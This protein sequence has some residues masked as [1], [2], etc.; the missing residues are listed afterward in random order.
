MLFAVGC[1]LVVASLPSLSAAEPPHPGTTDSDLNASE[2]AT[3]WSNVPPGRWDPQPGEG[4][5]IHEIASGTDLTFTEPPDTAQR[6]NEYGHEQFEP[7][8]RDT[9]VHPDSISTHSHSF[10]KDAHATVFSVNPST[11]A[12]VG[13]DETRLYLA[14]N[15]TVRG[16]VD[17]RID[18]PD[19]D[20]RTSWRLVDDEIDE[21]RLSADG[22]Q[23]DSTSGTHRP[24]FEYSL[25]RGTETLTLEARIEANATKTVRPPPDSNGTTTTYTHN[26]WVEVWYELS[27]DVY[28]FDATV[29]Q[30]EY[31]NGDGGLAITQPE[32]WQG[33]TLGDGREIRGIWRFFTARYPHWQTVVESNEGGTTQRDSDAYP[34]IVFMYPSRMSPRAKPEYGDP[35]ILETWGP[36]HDPPMN[37]MPW[38]AAVEI[39]EEPYDETHGMAVRADDVDPDDL[40]VHG[41]VHGTE[42]D[43]RTLLAEPR[44]L[45]EADLSASIVATNDSTATVLVELIDAETGDPIA[46]TERGGVIEVGDEQ[47][48]TNASGQA[49]IHLSEQGARTVRYDPA[50]WLDS[51]PSYTANTASVRWHPLSTPAGWLAAALR[52]GLIT[53]P[54]ALAWY[55]GRRLG[56]MFGVDG[57]R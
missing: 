22:E 47:V 3:L 32:P 21:V 36:T 40:T 52:V 20:D 16:V 10:V 9:S 38:N 17:Y 42:T 2:E 6:W 53:L 54:F 50:P 25:D 12:Y 30:V 26:V 28:E 51:N 33:Y 24:E 46:L 35:T 31:P 8:G 56:V 14:P 4:S 11:M 43:A 15:G 45:R 48:Q 1:L 13:P 19:G 5:V 55:A 49:T 23:I 29:N 39:V 7:G 27:V 18:L 57:W 44:Q 41:I 34:A 37:S